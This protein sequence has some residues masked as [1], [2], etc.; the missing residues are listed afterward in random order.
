MTKR[1]E[2]VSPGLCFR[3]TPGA[4]SGGSC[5]FS[6]CLPVGRDVLSVQRGPLSLSPDLLAVSIINKMDE[7]VLFWLNYGFGKKNSYVFIHQ[8]GTVSPASS[9]LCD[10]TRHLP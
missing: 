6:P 8:V 2:P 5:S 4:V 7:I 1:S 9:T 3:E 10:C